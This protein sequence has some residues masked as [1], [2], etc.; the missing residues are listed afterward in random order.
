ME[1]TYSK[2][3]LARR[4][5]AN[6]S[7]VQLILS[8]VL[9]ACV[10]CNHFRPIPPEI[11]KLFD[12]SSAQRWALWS[13]HRLYSR[14]L[15]MPG[16]DH[17]VAVAPQFSDHPAHE[18]RKAQSAYQF[19]QRD[20]TEKVK[21]DLIRLHGKFDIA[22]FGKAVR[23]RWNA[24]SD[25]DR[26]NYEELARQDMAR[27]AQ[28]SHEAD[29][30]A[31]HRREKLQQERETLLLDMEGG[32]KRLTRRVLEK[33]QRKISKK[34]KR[35]KENGKEDF[36]EPD[37]SDDWDSDELESDET[38]ERPKKKTT[39][40]TQV[41]QKQIEYRDK[42][43]K[44]KQEKDSYIANRQE[45]LRKERAAQAKR[46]LEF[47]LKQGG[48]IFSHFGNVKQ[49]TAKFGIKTQERKEG[50]SLTRRNQMGDEEGDE[51][52]EEADEH[53]ATYLTS[54]PSTLGFGKMRD[55]QLEGLNWMIRLQENGVNGILADEMGLGKVSNEFLK[56]FCRWNIT[57]LIH[58]FNKRLCNL[59]RFLFTC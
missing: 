52:L 5:S 6:S 53:E 8:S 46:R 33:K 45:D 19:F 42:I 27:F 30:A 56:W 59:S 20:M 17:W 24:L 36:E 29:V 3:E 1:F 35:R 9:L 38:N 44:E 57:G 34:E 16:E 21:E 41:S 55:Y 43:K 23:D 28:E 11:L 13:S 15:T 4:E 39:S 50:E 12:R 54:Q 48:D 7:W 40:R 26:R 31:M 25:L 10:Y 47:L 37:E 51:A 2:E 14:P 49:E 22:L 58:F 32:D 18:I